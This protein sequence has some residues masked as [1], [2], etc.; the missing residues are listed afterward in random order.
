MLSG[1]RLWSRRRG[2]V[3]WNG[4]FCTTVHETQ[5]PIILLQIKHNLSAQRSICGHSIL[6]G[7]GAHFPRGM[8]RSVQG[9]Q[10]IYGWLE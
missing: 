3:T 9:P 6:P 1:G 4:L 5:V 8:L 10:Y 7:R 2:V